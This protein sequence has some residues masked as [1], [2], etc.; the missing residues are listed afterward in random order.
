MSS[1]S[2]S[3]QVFLTRLAHTFHP[4]TSTHLQD[5]TQ[6]STLLRSKCPYQSAM[7]HLIN[8]TL[9]TAKAAHILI[10][11][12]VFQGHPTGRHIHLTIILSVLSRFF[13]F[14]AFIAQVLVPYEQNTLDTSFINMIPCTMEL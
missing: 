11:R 1:F 6:S 2:H 9:D 4:A 13:K 5:D 3:F 8:H 10:A 7:S 12:S 14:Y